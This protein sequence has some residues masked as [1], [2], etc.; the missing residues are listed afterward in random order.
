MVFLSVPSEDP[1]ELDPS[2]KI[3]DRRLPQKVCMTGS[4]QL[5][6]LAAELD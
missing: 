3:V 6:Q 2:S 5:K 4:I 1:V